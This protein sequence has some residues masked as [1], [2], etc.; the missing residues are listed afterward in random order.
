MGLAGAVPQ[1]I[2]SVGPLRPIP[3]WTMVQR[4]CERISGTLHQQASAKTR[5]HE[6]MSH[7]LCLGIR[8]ARLRIMIVILART[9]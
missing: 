1:P 6:A 8:G 9:K 3:F 2:P 7:K 4:L 5:L